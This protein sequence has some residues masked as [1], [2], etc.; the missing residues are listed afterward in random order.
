MYYLFFL[1]FFF[2][3]TIQ[4][5]IGEFLLSKDFP[6]FY[7]NTVMMEMLCYWSHTVGPFCSGYFGAKVSLYTQAGLDCDP[8]VFIMTGMHIIERT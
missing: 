3:V 8:P 4:T 6:S 1:L 2:S 7:R 5:T